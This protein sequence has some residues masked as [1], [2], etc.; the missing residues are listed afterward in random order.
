[1]NGGSSRSSHGRRS[2]GTLDGLAGTLARGLL[3]CG[4]LSGC[5]AVQTRQSVDVVAAQPAR[6]EDPRTQAAASGVAFLADADWQAH[7]ASVDGDLRA[8]LWS[9]RVD[10][11]AGQS[12]ALVSAGPQPNPGYRVTVAERSLPVRDHV[13]LVKAVVEAPPGHL[14]QAQVISFACVYLKL[15]GATYREVAVQVER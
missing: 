4:L 6:C 10:F 12:V 8:R 5:Q 11:T 7:L 1:M 3:A 9:W 13:L 15:D 14:I 2:S